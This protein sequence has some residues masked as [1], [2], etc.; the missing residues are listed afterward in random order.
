MPDGTLP[1][2][3]EAEAPLPDIREIDGFVFSSTPLGVSVRGAML[4]SERR[5]QLVS[6]DGAMSSD[7]HVD[8]LALLTV[9]EAGEAGLVPAGR[10]EVAATDSHVGSTVSILE[11]RE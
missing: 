2:D 9:A 1:P 3:E 11:A 10:L 8:R 7:R 4:E 5:R 6:P